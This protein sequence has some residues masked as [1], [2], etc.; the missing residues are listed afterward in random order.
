MK[1]NE[2]ITEVIDYCREFEVISID[3]IQQLCG[4]FGQAKYVAFIMERKQIL[5]RINYGKWTLVKNGV[6]SK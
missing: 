6:E 4:S 1:T 2:I 5:K 3:Q